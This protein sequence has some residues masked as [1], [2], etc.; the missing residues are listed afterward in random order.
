MSG[1]FQGLSAETAATDRQC[2]ILQL[3]YQFALC[4]K[5]SI[6]GREDI[7]MLLS[8]DMT[9]AT[10]KCRGQIFSRLC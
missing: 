4:H 2:Q 1:R 6:L 3:T 9:S 7:L 5:R 8:P 10:V